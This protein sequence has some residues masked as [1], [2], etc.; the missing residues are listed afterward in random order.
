[1]T[2]EQRNRRLRLLLDGCWKTRG[3]YFRSESLGRPQQ[4]A[5]E[6]LV[7]RSDSICQR[8]GTFV[9]ICTMPIRSTELVASQNKEMYMTFGLNLD[10]GADGFMGTG[11]THRSNSCT[12][13][14][15]LAA[16]AALSP[17]LS[18]VWS[19]PEDASRLRASARLTVAALC[20]TVLLL[21]SGKVDFL[22]SLLFLS[23]I[24]TKLTLAP[25]FKK[26]WITPGLVQGL[27]MTA[28]NALSSS[29]WENSH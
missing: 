10:T 3:H 9:Q 19:A 27:S 8:I 29:S 16:K 24:S 15:L 23:V 12:Q 5:Y 11:V 28:K 1:M 18:V 6:I 2:D 4:K 20:S 25:R 26:A 13:G 21:R 14:W 17:S 7:I 22:F